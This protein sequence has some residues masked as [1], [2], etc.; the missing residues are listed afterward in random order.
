[1]HET[2]SLLP[3]IRSRT[4][5]LAVPRTLAITSPATAA[6]TITRPLAKYDWPRERTASVKLTRDFLGDPHHHFSLETRTIH[7]AWRPEPR[8]HRRDHHDPPRPAVL[9]PLSEN[10]HQRLGPAAGSIGAT[11]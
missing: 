10:A 8:S 3:R 1:M 6:E 2:W 11:Q 4:R 9:I 7:P 5:Y